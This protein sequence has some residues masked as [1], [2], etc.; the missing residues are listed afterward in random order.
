MRLLTS[1]FI[2]LSIW[3]QNLPAQEIGEPIP[4]E[5]AENSTSLTLDFSK[6]DYELILYSIDTHLEDQSYGLCNPL[7]Y[8]V[9]AAF[10]DSNL[11]PDA[12]PDAGQQALLSERVSLESLMRARERELASRLQE[13]GGY[14]PHA[15]KFVPQETGS[16]RQFVF[17]AFG[18]VSKTTVT[19]LLVA[20]GE[21]AIVY[22]DV[23]D[24]HRLSKASLQ[25]QVDRFSKTIYPMVTSTFGSASDVDGDGKIHFLYTNRVNRDNS[26]FGS[27]AFFYAPSLLS[28]NQ[29]GDGNQSDMFYIDPDTDPTRI[30]AVLAHEFQHLINFNQHVLVRNGQPE[31]VWLN[32]GLS[33]FCEDLLGE[34]GAH[35]DLNVDFFLK[36]TASGP[37]G[38]T[39]YTGQASRGALYLFVR[40]LV[41][42]YGP[43]IVARLVQTDKTGFA[44]VEAGTATEFGD[45]FDRHAAR[46]FLSGLGLNAKFNYTTSPLAD[47]ISSARTFPLPVN[48][49]VWPG[50]GHQLDNR[51]FVPVRPDGSHA[52]TIKGE[53]YQLSPVYIRLYGRRKETTITIRTDPGGEF[54]A[55]II[56]IPVSYQPHIAIPAKYWPRVILDAPLPAQFR[57]GEAI[58][59]AGQSPTGRCPERLNSVLRAHYDRSTSIRR[60]PKE[61]ST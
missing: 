32:E 26:L 34:N 57:T 44:N 55:Q 53:L 4:V 12:N 28:V 6:C 31:D 56:P 61:D 43:G 15:A 50:G 48:A 10:G 42:E 59:V 11:A 23:A 33:H 58:P 46:L 45:I 8:S 52:V 19:A 14:R 5:I 2:L 54:R 40:S 3:I 35:N 1:L 37:L 20:S 25:E 39:A 13:S 27:A 38:T 36:R 47:D 49:L 30:D 18:D 17:P 21:R 16:T 41:E 51:G 24:V 9:T 29:G 7:G 22:V 60:I